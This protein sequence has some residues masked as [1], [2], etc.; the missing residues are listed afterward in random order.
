MTDRESPASLEGSTQC[1]NSVAKVAKATVKNLIG[2][3][4]KN[5]LPDVNLCDVLYPY[6]LDRWK[7]LTGKCCHMMCLKAIHV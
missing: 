3:S 6:S 4:L 5:C 7:H 2:L 1:L